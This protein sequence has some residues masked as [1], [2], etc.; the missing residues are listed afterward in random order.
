MRIVQ[1]FPKSLPAKAAVRRK[2]TI[3]PDSTQ[4]AAAEY[5]S[6]MRIHFLAILLFGIT[7]LSPGQTFF[8]SPDP[9][10]EQEVALEQANECY[11][12]FDNPSGDTLQLRWKLIEAS[13][14]PEWDIDLC[15]LGTCYVGIP[16]SGLMYA[17]AGTMQPYLKLI[18]QPGNTPGSGWLWFRVHEDNN[19]DNFA[20]VYFSLHTPGVSA[21]VEQPALA[22]RF[23]PNPAPEALFLENNAS[24][25][26]FTRLYN[27][28]GLVFWEGYIPA[29]A[30]QKISILSWPPGVYLIQS[31][32]ISRVLLHLN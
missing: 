18:V 21:V 10:L 15:D 6:T 20:D 14:P 16:A 2:A 28:N 8:P 19:P 9:L 22:L 13:Y 24:E 26:I 23:Y 17:A 12:F 32:G 11:M 25:A 30:R 3:L 5:Y 31:G 1:T 29:N 7:Q 4:Y 27:T